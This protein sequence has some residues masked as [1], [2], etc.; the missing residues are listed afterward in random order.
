MSTTPD[1]PHPPHQRRLTDFTDAGTQPTIRDVWE[2][3]IEIRDRM[4]YVEREQ[5]EQA[6]A[7]PINDLKKPDYDGH[8]R[9]HVDMIADQKIMDGYKTGVTKQVLGIVVVF[10]LGLIF[11]GLVSRLSDHIK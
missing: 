3:L 7:F 9:A 1:H 11:S 10:V 2:I 5:T 4:E 6:T 8:R